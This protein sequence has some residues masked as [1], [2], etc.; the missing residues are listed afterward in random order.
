MKNI[1]ALVGLLVV[2][3]AGAGWYLGWYKL[4]VEPGTTGHTKV[5]ADV[6]TDKIKQDVQNGAKKISD[7]VAPQKSVEGQTTSFTFPV[8][9]VK[10]KELAPPPLPT[11]PALQLN[12][13][14]TPKAIVIPPPPPFSGQ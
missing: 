5:N 8:G 11:L 13:D 3:F 9:E 14:G 4:G 6:D 12:P 10:L 1:L 2:G 7:F